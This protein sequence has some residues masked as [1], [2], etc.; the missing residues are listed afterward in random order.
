ML[1]CLEVLLVQLTKLKPDCFT[2]LRIVFNIYRMNLPP[3]YHWEI[4][5]AMEV[6]RFPVLFRLL[7]KRGFF[8][9]FCHL[10]LQARW[11]G[12]FTAALKGVFPLPSPIMTRSGET[13]WSYL[14]GVYISELLY[15]QTGQCLDTR[16]VC[17]VISLPYF[18]CFWLCWLVCIFLFFYFMI[19]C[20]LDNYTSY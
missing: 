4:I 16:R 17:L 20:F 18:Y 3:D 13:T 5:W 10:F 19:S 1:W 9:F 12:R 15:Y 7:S 14:V 11:G 2:C 6:S 8:F